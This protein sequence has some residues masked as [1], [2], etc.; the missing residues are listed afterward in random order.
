MRGHMSLDERAARVHKWLR[1]LQVAALNGAEP[2]AAA[3]GAE[4]A[5]GTVLCAL[6]GRLDPGTS[7]KE[8]AG[9]SWRPGTAAARH[10]NIAKALQV[11]GRLRAL[12]NSG[13]RDK[14]TNVF[15]RN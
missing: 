15:Y 14:I 6:L 12:H 10:H 9:I 7:G 8:L 5:D 2:T 1:S 4:L 11:R 3:L 13:L